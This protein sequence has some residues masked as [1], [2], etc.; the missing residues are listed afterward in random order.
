M[1]FTIKYAFDMETRQYIAEIPEL[2]LSDY[3]DTI[4]EAESNIKQTLNLY[5][6]EIL[7]TK[8]NTNKKLEYV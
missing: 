5:F 2:N 7:S 4:Q 3:W 6:E 1:N 8:L